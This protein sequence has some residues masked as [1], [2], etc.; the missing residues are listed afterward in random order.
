MPKDDENGGEGATPPTGTGDGATPPTT[1]PATGDSIGDAGRA[2]IKAERDAAKAAREEAKAATAELERI[3]AALAG[4]ESDEQTV[5]TARAE[6]EAAKAT[7]LR[8]KVAAEKGLP[9]DLIPRLV[10]DTEADLAADA[11]AL[12]ALVAKGKPKRK[13]AGAGNNGDGKP[14]ISPDAVLRAA[15]GR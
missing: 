10:G 15:L 2:A 1:P 4:K 5:A 11:D 9:A 6:A 14:A 12:I 13:D 8:Y 7:A 3:R